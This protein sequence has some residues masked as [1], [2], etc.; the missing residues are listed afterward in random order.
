M[1]CITT[2]SGHHFD[3]SNPAVESI[4]IEDIA[5]ALSHECRFAG[6]LPNFYSVAQHS[7]LMSQI[8]GAEFALEALLHDASEAYCKDIPSPLKRLLPDYQ[9]VERQIDWVIREKFG[10]PD[11]MGFAVHYCDLVMLATERRDLDI[12]DGKVWPMLEGIPPSGDITIIPVGPVQAR[13][14]FIQRYNELV[15]EGQSL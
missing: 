15:G 1:T 9:A 5:Q 10:L 3:Y 7:V 12:D 4:C 6:H 14:M 8:I 13:A 11:G 2:F